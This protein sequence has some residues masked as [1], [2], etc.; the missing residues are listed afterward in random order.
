MGLLGGGGNEEVGPR[1]G[2]PAGMCHWRPHFIFVCSL[3]SWLPWGTKLSYHALVPWCFYLAI[4]L[5]GREPANHG[6]KPPTPRTKGNPSSLKLIGSSIFVTAT[7][8]DE[9]TTSEMSWVSQLSFLCLSSLA[10]QEGGALSISRGACEI[11]NKTRCK[12]HFKNFQV[13]VI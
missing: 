5:R 4:G 1:G 7:K 12:K 11:M 6:L 13:L 8:T 9:A 10:C 2:R 3:P